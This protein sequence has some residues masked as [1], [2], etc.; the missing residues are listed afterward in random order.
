MM[1]I[2]TFGMDFRKGAAIAKCL[3]LASNLAALLLFLING[4]IYFAY[5]V[6][7]AISMV[8]GAKFGTL[9]ALKKGPKWI[10]PIFILVSA[11]LVIKMIFEHQ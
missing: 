11:S 3:N 2:H 1:L 8:L 9:F 7:M 10:K 6:V 5:G 4:Q